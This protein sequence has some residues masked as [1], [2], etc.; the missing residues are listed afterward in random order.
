MF[1]LET[2]VASVWLGE[3]LASLPNGL[4]LGADLFTNFVAPGASDLITF[5]I[6]SVLTVKKVSS[7]H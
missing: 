6:T 5:V 2:A 4:R 3:P 7:E 1:P